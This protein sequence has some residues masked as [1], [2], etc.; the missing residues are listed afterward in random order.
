[1]CRYAGPSSGIGFRY[2]A[3]LSGCDCLGRPPKVGTTA[4]SAA[5]P[6]GDLGGRLGGQIQFQFRQQEAELG[7]GLGVAGEQQFAAVGGRQA[8]KSVR[9]SL[10]AGGN[11]IRPSVPRDATKG[12]RGL[13]SPRL[14]PPRTEKSARTR[15]DTKATPGAFRGTDGS[16]PVPSSGESS[17]NP[18]FWIVVGADAPSTPLERGAR[19]DR[20]QR[21]AVV[22]RLLACDKTPRREPPR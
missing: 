17:A 19:P 6:G 12:S 13:M 18:I 21:G 10:I 5:R 20:I 16:N 11:R 14:D 15:L 4:G 3:G 8:R 1:M 9:I 2:P 7:F 22:R